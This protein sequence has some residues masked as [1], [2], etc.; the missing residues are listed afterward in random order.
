MKTSKKLA[1][2]ALTILAVI[3]S[4]YVIISVIIGIRIGAIVRSSNTNLGIDNPYSSIISDKD[5]GRLC[6]RHPDLRD[7][8]PDIKYQEKHFITPVITLYSLTQGRAYFLYWYEI[9]EDGL[10]GSGSWHIPVTVYF[11]FDGFDLKVTRVYEAP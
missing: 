7:P 1:K 4:A 10:L 8:D 2:A 11:E 9:Y 5:Y 6:Q 3:V